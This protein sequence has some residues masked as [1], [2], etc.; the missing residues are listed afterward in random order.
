MLKRIRDVEEHLDARTGEARQFG[1][2]IAGQMQAVDALAA[3]TGEASAEVRRIEEELAAAAA[4]RERL[5]EMSGACARLERRV[6]AV[7]TSVA[8][9]DASIAEL[10]SRQA[11]LPDVQRELTRAEQLSGDVGRRVTELRNQSRHVDALQDN[12]KAMEQAVARLRPGVAEISDTVAACS[13]RWRWSPPA[14]TVRNRQSKRS[15]RSMRQWR[16]SRAARSGCRSPAS[17]WRAP[18][19]GW[20][21]SATGA[22]PASAAGDRAQG[23]T[24]RRALRRRLRFELGSRAM[25]VKLAGQGWSVPEISRATR[26]SRGEVEL[27]PRGERFRKPDGAR[28]RSRQ[29]AL[30]GAPD[31]RSP[32]V[33]EGNP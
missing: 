30:T 13:G 7:S 26:L 21:R 32:S 23:G 17:G 18:R 3:R 22:G 33:Q 9:V 2:R 16:K 25:V 11:E 5:D 15:P 6:E 27:S 20:Q 4:V 14:P 28:Q 12:L 31:R 10:V 24:R 29:A 19:R 1:E 8:G